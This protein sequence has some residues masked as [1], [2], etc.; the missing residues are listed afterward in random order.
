MEDSGGYTLKNLGE[1]EDIAAKH[2]FGEQ[3]EA[4]FA[5]AD[6]DAQHTGISLHHLRPGMRQAF[7]HRHTE[8]EEVY[9]VLSG[10]G[11]IAL[12]HEVLE[13]RALDAVRVA[14]D[15]TRAFEA[16]ADG[17]QILAVGPR[18][19]GDGEIVPGWWAG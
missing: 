13:L 6:L 4:R 2:G 18:H 1:V 7:G 16:G 15:V 17:M 9:V 8:A 12:G 19:E 10:S 3:G 14:P 11:S 5:T